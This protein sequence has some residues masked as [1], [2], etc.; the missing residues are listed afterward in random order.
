[1]S[2][3]DDKFS[4][5]STTKL[6]S[7]LARSKESWNW[8][9]FLHRGR[10]EL[11]IV[12]FSSEIYVTTTVVTWM[13]F[14]RPHCYYGDAEKKTFFSAQTLPHFNITGSL[15]SCVCL[16]FNAKSGGK[17]CNGFSFWWGTTML[18]LQMMMVWA[19]WTQSKDYFYNWP[20]ILQ[21]FV[22][23][24]TTQNHA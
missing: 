13:T 4:I 23:E 12:V 10:C 18:F 20:L 22:T 1:M 11:L 16:I 17:P 7:R 14:L 6:P 2:L 9:S 19:H 21:L 8:R 5:P 3:E 24:C 15:W